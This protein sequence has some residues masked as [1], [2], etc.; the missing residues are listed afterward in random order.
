MEMADH[1]AARMVHNERENR[2]KREE[3]KL[4]ANIRE[5]TCAVQN[6]NFRALAHQQ[7]MSKRDRYD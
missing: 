5:K 2:D 3:E 1:D 4:V 6:E 7:S